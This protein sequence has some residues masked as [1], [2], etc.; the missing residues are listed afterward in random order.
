[1]AAHDRS[2]SPQTQMMEKGYDPQ[3]SEGAAIPPVFRTSTFVFRSAQEGKRAFEVAY[4]LRRPDA[5]ET[6]ALIY[7]RVNNP[8]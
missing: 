8:N 6:P 7:T 2:L 1:M 5:G 4:G 3:L